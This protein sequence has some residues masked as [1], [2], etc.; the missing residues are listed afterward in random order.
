[1]QQARCSSVRE[2]RYATPWFSGEFTV[3]YV[4]R[5]DENFN[6]NRSWIMGRFHN[7]ICV[8]LAVIVYLR[9]GQL[10]MFIVFDGTHQFKRR[11]SV[12]LLKL[13]NGWLIGFQM[14]K[15]TY[16]KVY[17]VNLTLVGLLA[18]RKRYPW[19]SSKGAL[20]ARSKFRREDSV[21]LILFFGTNYSKLWLEI[22]V[23]LHNGN[24]CILCDLARGK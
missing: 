1:M 2:R 6:T 10:L 5:T 21:V 18:V 13:V 9:L 11:S 22:S 15:W 19:N 24:S 7:F 4:L 23:P 12:P 8:T 14:F 16:E 3:M 17:V 20:L